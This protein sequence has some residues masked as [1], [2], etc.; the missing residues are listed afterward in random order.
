MKTKIIF[1]LLMFCT[2]FLFS[3]NKNITIS[4]YVKEKGS[5]ELLI[6]V[7]VYLKGTLYGTTSNS[8]GFYSLTFPAQSGEVAFSYVGFTS[9]V[10]KENFDKDKIE[11]TYL[12]VDNLLDEV[13]VTADID[14]K[15][16]S[17]VEMSV[18][19]LKANQ[20]NEIPALLGE[21]DVFKTLQL[22][23]GVRSG[24][25]ASSG[26][27]VRGGGP[28]QNLVIL[29]DAPV[30]NAMHLFGFFSVFN[31][32]AIK[33]IEMF[34]GGFPARFGGRLSSVV[35][36]SMKDGNK[37]E[38]GG[39][40]SIGL[41]SSNLILE[42][43]IGKNKKSS[44]IVSGRRTYIDILT[45]PII[46]IQSG[47]T[48]AG[49]YFYDLNAKLNYE[50]SNRDKLYL[51]GYF[52]KDRFYGNEE[53]EQTELYWQ[54]ATSTVRWN[55]LFSGKLFSN[56]SFI[57]SNYN[58]NISSEENYTNQTSKSSYKSG[59]R[60]FSLKT[61]F[62]WVPNNFNYIRF[63][64]SITHHLFTPS[65]VRFQN[66]SSQNDE[67]IS[68]KEL[69]SVETSAYIEDEWKVTSKIKVNAG[70]RL[71]NFQHESTSYFKI[72]PRLLTSFIIANNMS[73]KA[74]YTEMNQNIHLLTST[75][76]GLPTDLW[77][78]A[79]DRIAPQFARQFAVG[80]DKDFDK[81]TL[82]VSL[83]GYYKAMNDI[84]SYKEGA[85]FMMIS[86]PDENDEFNYEDAVTVGKGYSYG[87]ELLIRKKVGKLTGWIGYTL[88]LTKYK[89]D[90]LNNGN[91]F[92]PRHD[93]RHDISVVGVYK[94]SENIT[95]SSTWVYGTGDA[96]TLAGSTYNATTNDANNTSTYND[97][98]QSI[99]NGYQLGNARGVSYY[100]DKN[101]FRMGAYHRLDFGARFKKVL[102]SGNTRTWEVSVYNIYNRNNPF[103]YENGF[104]YETKETK[105]YQVSL[106]PI[107]PSVSYTLKF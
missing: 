92:F 84:I 34:K 70:V 66:S 37:S 21:K 72:E 46:K 95:L 17:K 26:L 99:S 74:S 47:G 43:P 91:E 16:S 45:A 75:G 86:N 93:R 58:L 50:I 28:D 56:T 76:I 96:I 104:D 44:F 32:N 9:I 40:A 78:P 102:E 22:M 101:S 82:S 31:G 106:F 48:D 20:I 69:N 13:V 90:D 36:I 87:A 11:N 42:G 100:N 3:Q 7:N 24:S 35:D 89:F 63:G 49:Y 83:E 14:E 57:Y 71:N 4:G 65:A 52:G 2:S 27:Y 10:L 39:E 67:S 12:V 51:S 60:D 25:E 79:T 97:Y 68:V 107:I 6:G 105:L 73:V 64:A 41:I 19:N 8:Y 30:Y 1:A 23:P 88:S 38:F 94:L 33:N 85:N 18:L 15:I 103:Y 77:V 54:N 29:D 53:N 5:E 81:P 62:T 98:L 61:D 80:I 55:H 59:I